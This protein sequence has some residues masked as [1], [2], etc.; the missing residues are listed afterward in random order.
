MDEKEEE[1]DE[2]SSIINHASKPPISNNPSNQADPQSFTITPKDLS[3]LMNLYKDRQ[4]NYNDI[5]YFKE[6]GGI[7]PLLLSLKT[8]AKQGI[9]TLSLENR[10]SHFGS[11]R[12]YI[13]PPPNFADFCI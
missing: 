5:K 2:T 8:D 12:I 1:N 9:S 7:L 6:K 11:N 4:G 3:N 13:K 10:K